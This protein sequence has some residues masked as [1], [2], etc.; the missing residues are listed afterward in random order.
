MSPWCTKIA[1][2][3]SILKLRDS[4]FAC[5]PDFTRRKNHILGARLKEDFLNYLL[6]RE[7]KE[8]GGRR[9]A[10]R[11]NN[12]QNFCFWYLGKVKKFQINTNMCL[13]VMIIS[14]IILEHLEVIIL[15]QITWKTMYAYSTSRIFFCSYS[16]I[17]KLFSRSQ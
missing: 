11:W 16:L 6:F 5:K 1:I 12:D 10:G 17:E 4:S 9:Q 14:Q 8:E 3:H 2:T 15:R 7:A 13:G